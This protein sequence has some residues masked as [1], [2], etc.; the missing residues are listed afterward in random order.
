MI[1]IDE[2]SQMRY[3]RLLLGLRLPKKL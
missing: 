1:R 2:L 3:F